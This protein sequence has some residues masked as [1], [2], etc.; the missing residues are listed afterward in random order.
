MRHVGGGRGRDEPRATRTTHPGRAEAQVSVLPRAPRDR[1]GESGPSVPA[2]IEA[3]GS[4]GASEADRGTGRIRYTDFVVHEVDRRGRV[5][6]L[7]DV[8]TMPKVRARLA[9]E[10]CTWKPT[11]RPW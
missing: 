8:H 4:S 3:G 9:Q 11:R 2:R 7:E 6:V 10:R 1:S 5:V